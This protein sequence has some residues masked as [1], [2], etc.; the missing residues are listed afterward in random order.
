MHVLLLLLWC[1]GYVYFTG[2]SGEGAGE[3]TCLSLSF[4][5][6]SFLVPSL[7][8]LFT[9]S[10]FFSLFSLFFSHFVPVTPNLRLSCVKP[11]LLLAVEKVSTSSPQRRRK[12]R[13]RRTDEDKNQDQE[14]RLDWEWILVQRLSL[15]LYFSWTP[16]SLFFGFASA[17]FS[18][19]HLPLLF[20]HHHLLPWLEWILMRTS[21]SSWISKWIR[22]RDRPDFCVDQVLLWSTCSD[23]REERRVY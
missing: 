2:T 10:F 8:S 5:L 6:I 12:R 9:C 22:Q 7:V 16:V 13:R 23:L 15:V 20:F 19:F 4:S 17:V 1:R 18:A 11:C 3:V 14:K 21:S